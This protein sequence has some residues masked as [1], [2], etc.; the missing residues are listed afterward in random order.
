MT[1]NFHPRS[2]RGG[3]TSVIRPFMPQHGF[4]GCSCL[5]GL[6]SMQGFTA[7]ASHNCTLQFSDIGVFVRRRADGECEMKQSAWRAD[8]KARLS[9]VLSDPRK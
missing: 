4:P 9:W 7:V 5:L 8:D 2:L 1:S 3:G 6:T